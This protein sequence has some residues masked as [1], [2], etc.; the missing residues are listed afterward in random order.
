MSS[1]GEPLTPEVVNWFKQDL[2]VNIF[3]QYGQ[4]E[5][6]MVIA[7]HHALEHPL[8]VGSAGF[9]IPGHRF[10][11]LDQIIKNYQQVVLVFWQWTRSNPH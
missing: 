3:D 8:K 2:E 1:A 5:L 9:A 11:V 6:G 4:T 7:N 10:A